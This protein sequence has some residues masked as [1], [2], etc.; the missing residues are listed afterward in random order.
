MKEVW[1]VY[2][3]YQFDGY[4]DTEV[5]SSKEK[6]IDAADQ[7]IFE[8]ENDGYKVTR[9]F[10]KVTFEEVFHSDNRDVMYIRLTNGNG[11]V[12]ITVEKKTVH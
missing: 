3:I 2:V 11:E 6:A 12:E 10:E 9:E 1:L 4:G 8:F 5:Y 7:L